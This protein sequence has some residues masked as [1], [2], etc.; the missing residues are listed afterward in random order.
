MVSWQWQLRAIIKADPVY[1]YVRSCKRTQCQ[2]FYGHLTF[3][4]NW[5]VKKLGKWV[6]H[7]LTENQKDVKV[8]SSLILCNNKPF[9]DWIVMCYE[10]W[11]L[12]NNQL[13]VVPRRSSKALYKA[14]LAPKKGSWSL[15]GDLTPIWS[16]T[17]LWILLK[18][19][20][21]RSKLSRSMRCI[22]NYNACRWQ[23]STE[24]A[25][26]FSMTTPNHM[27]HNQKLLVV[28]HTASE[29]EQIGLQS[30][31]LSTIFTWPPTNQLLP[32]LQ[33][34]WQ[35]FQGEHFHN[36][37][38]AEKNTFQ[39]SIESWCT[40]FYTTGINKLI[41]HRQKCVDCNGPYFD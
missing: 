16:T 39:E 41:F 37:Q 2:P 1:N 12:Y 30:F 25:Q 21:L 20:H 33:A 31:A 6:S 23:W 27:S 32:L 4:A 17:A 5:K 11:I 13:S 7:E 9:L 38:E 36:Q 22:Q 10:K 14:K 29:V 40:D 19:L 8:S 24:W 15:F 18:L 35:L 28:W 3:E 26:F 34:S